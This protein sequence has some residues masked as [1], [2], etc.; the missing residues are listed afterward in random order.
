MQEYRPQ[1]FEILPLVVKNLM[2]INGLFFLATIVLKNTYQINL[3]D[4]LGLHFFSSPY[5]TPH[6]IITHMFM[7]D[8]SS[9]LHLA[10][11]MFALWMFGAMIENYWG[12]K[13]FLTFYMIC[14]LGGAFMHM[15]VTAY[16]M[17]LVQ[18]DVDL[19]YL[20]ST[21][22]SFKSLFESHQNILNDDA[23]VAIANK[24]YAALS[25][26]PN[27]TS[28][29]TEA[30]RV[31]MQLPIQI[32]NIPVIGASGAVFGVLLAFGMLFPNTVIYLYFF[33]P[34]KAKY[35]VAIYGLFELYAGVT[36]TQSGVAHFAHLGGMLFGFIMIKYWNKNRR[37]DFY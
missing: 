19:F 32:A 37:R 13:R 7:H 9:I 27:S 16:Q 36:G 10:S 22:A 30:R 24:A 34:L 21:A 18:N 11:N 2:I 5:F 33:I 17:H 6:Q 14:G 25:L 28:S 8:D 4:Y 1:R 31:A 12:P 15:G 20:N 3:I 35:F 26:D 29:I 23:Y